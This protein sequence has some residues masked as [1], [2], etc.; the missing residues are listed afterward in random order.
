MLPAQTAPAPEAA[1]A[2][3]DEEVVLDVFTINTDKD[4][5]YVAVDSLAGGRTN[6]PIKFT[7]SVMSSL[8][9]TFIDDVAITNVRDALKWSPN[10]V[11]SDY[12]VG[13]QLANPFNNWDYN[14]RGAGQSLQG[15]AGPTRNYFTFYTAA[16]S[17]NIDRIEFDRGPNS[18]LFGVGT[19]GGVLSTYTKIPKLDKNFMNLTTIVDSNSSVRAEV[20]LNNRLTEK[21]ALRI[22]ALVDRNRGWR[23]NDKNDTNAIDLAM[24][25]RPTA[26]TSLRF[27]LEGAQSEITLI[28]SLLGDG[29]SRWDG[30]SYSATWGAPVTGTITRPAQSAGWW[31]DPYNVWI[32]GLAEKGAMDWNGGVISAGIDPDGIPFA[33]YEGWYKT[34]VPLYSWMATPPS[35]DKIPVLP[36]RDFTYGNGISEPEYYNGTVWFDQRLNENLDFSVSGYR[37]VNDHSAKDYEGAGNIYVDLNRQLPDGTPNPNVGKQFADFF[38]SKQQQ[39]RTVSELRAQVNYK[40]EGEIFNVPVKQLFSVAGGSQEITWSARQYNAQLVGTGE[41]DF[42]RNM[43]WG[44]LYLDKPNQTMNLPEVVNGR[45]VSYAGMPF[46]WFD[47]DETYK[48]KNL[49]VVSQTRLWDDALSILAGARKDDYEHRKVGAHS[50]SVVED[51]A[52]GTTY[53]L[54]AIY[55]WKSIG[56]FANYSE[57]FD[58]IGPG[59]Q[60]GL[61]GNPF[62]PAKG[63]SFEYGIR[64]STG[65][66]KYYASISRYDSTSS[67]RI[68]NGGKPDF[69]GMWRNYYDSLNQPWDT[70][71]TTLPYDDTEAL[72]VSGTEIDFVANPL[73]SLRLSFTFGKPDSEIVDALPGARAYYDQYLSTWQTATTPAPGGS[74]TAAQNLQNQIASSKNTLDQNVAGK[75]KTGL[76]DYTASIFANYSFLGDTLKGFSIGGGLAYTGEQYVGEYGAPDGQPKF[77]HYSDDRLATNMVLAYEMKIGDIPARFQLNIDNVLD[78]KDPIVTSY[79]WG[80]IV[81]PGHAMPN[82]YILPAPRTFRLSA[83][84]TF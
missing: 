81:S 62:G 69:Q 67:G 60:N 29:I 73:K 34:F 50:G 25:Y 74:A 19:V 32:P 31:T 78:D 17:Y 10:V 42:A 23:E 12:F 24:I 84:F 3:D 2:E 9:R 52:D 5:G 77:A 11:P 14:F 15:G 49:G 70:S 30:S 39:D 58:P 63:E 71:R 38:L 16:D 13:K 61:D 54:G 28:S 56:L 65:D 21:V 45:A 4:E 37:Y 83:R 68:F 8:T 22:N 20:D 82:G 26:N 27:E 36:S 72:D 40:I 41:T 76:V 55:Y 59:K 46:D 53:S 44:R 43:I 33:P 1:A 79:H 66:G 7:P 51:G 47:F 57:N 75:T 80:W 18:I 48:L 6:T 35:P 64:I